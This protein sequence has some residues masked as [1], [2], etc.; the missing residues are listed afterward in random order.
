MTVIRKVDYRKI[1]SY[2]KGLV[3][4]GLSLTPKLSGLVVTKLLWSVYWEKCIVENGCGVHFYI[5]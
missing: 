5:C 1:Q 2:L 3:S 4:D